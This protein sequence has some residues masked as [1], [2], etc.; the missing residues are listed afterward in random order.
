MTGSSST[1]ASAP[2]PRREILWPMAVPQTKPAGK[3]ADP[4]LK[5]FAQVEQVWVAR[6]NGPG[7]N[8]RNYDDPRAMIV[9]ADGSVLVTGRSE[10]TN[11]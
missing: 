3:D 11:S 10:G 9:E 7:I 5:A 8:G 1:T 6:Y 2:E 4:Y